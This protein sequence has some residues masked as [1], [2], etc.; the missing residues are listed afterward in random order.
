MCK[1]H[2]YQKWLRAIFSFVLLLFLHVIIDQEDNTCTAKLWTS[3]TSSSPSFGTKG[4]HFPY[5]DSKAKTVGP[6][7]IYLIFD[8]LASD[9]WIAHSVIIRPDFLV[10]S[11]VNAPYFAAFHIRAYSI[12]LIYI[13]CP[14]HQLQLFKVICEM[15]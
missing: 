14:V 1:I 9:L 2:I 6:Q 4:K 15:P 8:V 5:L 13:C 3:M 11:G 12:Y 7:F 10:D